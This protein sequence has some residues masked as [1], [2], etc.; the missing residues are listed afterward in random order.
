MEEDI[1]RLDV[2]HDSLVHETRA[3]LDLMNDP[4]RPRITSKNVHTLK[5][6]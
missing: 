2:V 3:I 4:S 5:T 6:K 1:S